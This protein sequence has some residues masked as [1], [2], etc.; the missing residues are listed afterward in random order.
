M[1]KGFGIIYKATNKIN[2]KS[3][4]G[5][6]LYPLNIRISQHKHEAIRKADNN[7][8]HKAIRKYGV[9]NFEWET[10][11]EYPVKELNNIEIK[12]IEKYN[13]CGEGYNLTTGG[14]GVKGVC[15][16]K[17]RLYGKRR[18]DKVKDK[19]KKTFEENGTVKGKNNPMYGRKHSEKA[20]ER[21][22]N[23]KKSYWLIVYPNGDKR[24]VTRLMKFCDD[25]GLCWTH[26]Y[27]VASS[28][29]SHHK[30]YKCKKIYE[31]EIR[32]M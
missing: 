20:K 23:A 11:G 2:G 22:I 27:S 30:G 21:M 13:T 12:T 15:G 25:G 3:Y 8:F 4:I 29:I 19:I 9:E 14:D 16:E 6:T 24:V 5:Q 31:L 18:S 26:M 17:H 32:R 7:Y 1:D 28:N 10:L